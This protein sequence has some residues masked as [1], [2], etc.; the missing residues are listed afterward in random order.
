MFAVYTN[1]METRRRV[2]RLHRPGLYFQSPARPTENRWCIGILF[3]KRNFRL[4]HLKES[5]WTTILAKKFFS[6]QSSSQDRGFL[7]NVFGI[8]N[9]WSKCMEELRLSQ[10]Y[11]KAIHIIY[12]GVLKR[13]QCYSF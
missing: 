11:L 2:E 5:R 6:S 10:L 4:T 12:K 13:T 9:S 7:W 3:F 8:M 1:Q